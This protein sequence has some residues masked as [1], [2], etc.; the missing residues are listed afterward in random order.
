MR[1]ELETLIAPMLAF[2]SQVGCKQQNDAVL[3]R[4]WGQAFL[5]LLMVIMKW[6]CE[7]V[8]KF[9]FPL[10]QPYSLSGTVQSPEETED[11]ILEKL[12]L[13]NL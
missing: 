11:C 13:P 4:K 10:T 2:F 12:K 9:S 6:F 1:I 3:A 5:N 8:S 7:C